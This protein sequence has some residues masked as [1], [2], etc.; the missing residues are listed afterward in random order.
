MIIVQTTYPNDGRNLRRFMTAVLKKKLATCIQR[1]N[2]VKS[3]YGWEWK[4]AKTEEKIL[5][6]KTTQDK[7]D[8]LMNFIHKLHPYDTPEI[9]VIQPDEVDPKYLEWVKNPGPIQ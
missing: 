3:Y 7:K 2:N 9:I 4:I 8:A 6:I 5:L 1:I